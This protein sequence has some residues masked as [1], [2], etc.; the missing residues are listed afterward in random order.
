M[1]WLASFR[2]RWRNSSTSAMIC[3]WGSRTQGLLGYLAPLANQQTSVE[4]AREYTIPQ[5][6]TFW[7][8]LQVED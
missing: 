7:K 2:R 3:L 1:L 5:N 8:N 6:G 4:L